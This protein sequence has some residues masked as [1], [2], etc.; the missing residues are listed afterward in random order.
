MTDPQTTPDPRIPAVMAVINDWHGERTVEGLAREVLAAVDA[1]DS[2]RKT[3]LLNAAVPR[4]RK[5]T[6]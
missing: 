3:A 5:A 4:T 1:V 6:P 2:L